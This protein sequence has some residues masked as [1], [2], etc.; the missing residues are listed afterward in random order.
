M[1]IDETEIEGA[2]ILDFGFA[3]LDF[4]AAR[5]ASNRFSGRKKKRFPDFSRS[6]GL[7]STI[8]NPQS[9]ILIAGCRNW[10]ERL[11][12]SFKLVV[13]EGVPAGWNREGFVGVRKG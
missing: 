7:K 4:P 11:N 13:T 8:R 6:A 3:I 12:K 2:Y 5:S 10:S 1:V 9:K